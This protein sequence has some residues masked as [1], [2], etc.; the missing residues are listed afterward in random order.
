MG[1]WGYPSRPPS[2]EFT[3]RGRIRAACGDDHEWPAQLWTPGFMMAEMRPPRRKAAGNA[4]PTSKAAG[5]ASPTSVLSYRLAPDVS[6]APDN[7]G[8]ADDNESGGS[9]SVH[10]PS[11]MMHGVVLATLMVVGVYCWPS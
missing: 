2:Q 9:P 10:M 7:A 3:K 6:T 4:S 1:G 5:D 8:T 11:E